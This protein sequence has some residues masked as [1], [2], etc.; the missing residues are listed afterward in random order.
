MCDE[1]ISWDKIEGKNILV[2]GATGL[3]GHSI[4]SAL[5]H[6]GANTANPPQVLALVRNVDKAR[7]LYEDCPQEHLKLIVGD[8]TNQSNIDEKIDYIIH[9]ASLTQS[10]AFVT[11]PVEVIRT[12][13]LG[14]VNMLELA[15]QKHVES[16]VYL[17]SME[18]YGAHQSD[19]KVAE[20]CETNLDTMAVRSGYPESKRMCESLCT[21]YFNEYGVPAKVVRLTQTFGPGVEY[22]DGRVFAEFS[23][24]VIDNRDIVLHTKGETKRSYLYT[25]DAVTAI[26]TV[27]TK[28][29]NGQAYNAAN[30]E[31]YCSIYDMAAMV[32]S[33]IANNNIQVR[34]EEDDDGRY[35]YAPVLK[36]NLDTTKLR[37][38][39]WKGSTSL[40]DMFSNMLQSMSGNMK[41]DIKVSVILPAL[42]VGK[43]IRQCIESVVNQ[44]LKDIEIICVDAG[45]TDGTL[46]VL[47]EYA[48]KDER[49]TIINSPVKSYGY[50]MNLGIDASHGEYIGIVDTDDYIATDMYERLYD[51]A[52]DTKVDYVKSRYTI[53]Y[54]EGSRAYY[55]FQGTGR[56]RDIAGKVTDFEKNP[57]YRFCCMLPYWSGIYRKDF[58]CKNKI[59]FNETL[60]ASFQDTGFSIIVGCV[61][62]SA[63]FINDNLYFYRGDNPGSSTKVD[64]K[65]TCIVDELNHVYK[66]LSDNG[67]TDAYILREVD[68]R[69]LGRYNWNYKRLSK[70]SK[71]KFIDAIAG[72]MKQYDV[73][74]LDETYTKCYLNLTDKSRI[75]VQEELEK[76][77]DAWNQ[78]LVAMLKTGGRFNVV[79]TGYIFSSLV[80]IQKSMGNTFIGSVS[81]NS[82]AMWGRE[83]CGYKVYSV[84]ELA[85]MN[86]DRWLIAT[87]KYT[88]EIQKQ[89]VRLGIPENRITSLEDMYTVLD[90]GAKGYI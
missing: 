51:Y 53:F 8:V 88:D 38:L 63:V 66:Y 90:M 81:D 19:D 24:C 37:S 9:G 15:R 79:C 29:E 61:S 58:L 22:G 59:R 50:Q 77:R 16:F 14:T 67:I 46:E 11:N 60:G 31:T 52:A 3:I 39:G 44:T 76:E 74:L 73:D 36:M 56:I 62:K 10:R 69:R 42:N 86:D 83:V 80:E 26:L 34:I 82:K 48:A 65:V 33:E 41:A 89:L 35:G 68:L 28:G 55:H 47:E 13:V 70:A 45:S 32:T 72:E 84:E 4:V 23:R 27:L 7:R 64:S 57:Q 1:C 49:I 25:E 2:T 12:A 17:S 78:K 21:S 6:Y 43:Y 20:T 87:K 54:A 85:G 40:K 18:V 75:D 30:E 71:E 5:L